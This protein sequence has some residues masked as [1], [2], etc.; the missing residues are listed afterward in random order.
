[1]AYVTSLIT[2][3]L[4]PFLMRGEDTGDY[5]LRGDASAYP[6]GGLHARYFNDTDLAAVATGQYLPVC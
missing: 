3:C 6:Y 5:V 4:Q 1:M 2:E